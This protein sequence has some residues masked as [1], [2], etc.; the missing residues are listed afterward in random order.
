L[1]LAPFFLGR[2]FERTPPAETRPSAMAT[3]VAPP[4]ERREGR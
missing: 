1:L 2:S 4:D 3:R